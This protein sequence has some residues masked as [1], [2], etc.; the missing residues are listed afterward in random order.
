MI[1]AATRCRAAAATGATPVPFPGVNPA[2]E[3]PEQHVNSAVMEIFHRILSI[4]VQGG[5]SDVHVKVGT[6]V[7]FRINRQLVSIEAPTPTD[8][9]MYNI[10]EK[11][12]PKHALKRLEENREVD[13]SYYAPSVGRF[14]TNVFQ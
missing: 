13:F 1:S 4:A 2:G 6:P 14:R 12:V 8:E 11:I 5:A 7:V 9:W 10:V 3:R